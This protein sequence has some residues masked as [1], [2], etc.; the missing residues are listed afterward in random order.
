MADAPPQARFRG[1]LL[2]T[3]V[4]DAL[5]APFEGAAT[6]R[7]RD[8]DDV[9]RGSD[10][11]RW[12]DDT[13]M[14][15]AVAE[16]LAEHRGFDGPALARRFAEE[17]RREP[18]RGYGPGPPQ[19]FTAVLAGAP[20]DEPGRKLF[21][22]SGSFG[23]GG[24]MRAA[25]AGLFA[26]D[27]LPAAARLARQ[28]A[29]ITHTHEHG[30]QGAAL[31]ASAVAWLVRAQP[32]AGWSSPSALLDEIRAYAPAPEFS[33]K[34]MFIATLRPHADPASVAAALGNG[35]AAVESVPAALWAFLRHPG[36][37]I[38][39][40]RAA[41]TLGGDTDTVAAMAGALSG[42]FLGCDAIP[43]EWQQRLEA[44]DRLVTAADRLWSV[45]DRPSSDP[46][47]G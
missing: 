10:Q 46:A 26:Y 45:A 16:S 29:A 41:I 39:T 43:A 32:T 1:A 21:G 18:W 33:E 47:T 7:T 4:G 24:A 31:Q 36:S 9:E 15:L 22:G 25:P 38:D 27:S 8:L 34:L 13:A 40:V 42:A 17:H 12:T 6:V 20:W 5:G 35:V 28:Q 14:T 3:A 37:F 23:N 19:I 30:L 11:L 2:G 44:R